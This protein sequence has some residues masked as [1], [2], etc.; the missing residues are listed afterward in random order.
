MTPVMAG[1][2]RRSTVSGMAGNVAPASDA[3]GEGASS[4]EPPGGVLVWLVIFIELLTFAAGLLSFAV[5]RNGEPAVFAAGRGALNQPLAL[6]NTIVLL[7]GGWTMANGLA[8]LRRCSVEASGRWMMGAIACGGLFL[9]LKSVEYADKLRHGLDLHHDTFFTFYW[10]LTGFHV[11][12]VLA[13]VAILGALLRGVRAGR[14]TSR[15]LLDV[16]SGAAF[17]HLCDLIWLLLYPTVYLL[18]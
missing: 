8:S 15:D 5:S 17:W 6:A 1:R 13:A 18:A 14:Y 11:L 2:S 9:A 3:A 16:E 12:H 7:T 10:L 4:L